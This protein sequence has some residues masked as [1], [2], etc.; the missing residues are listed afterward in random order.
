MTDDA[1]GKVLCI[2]LGVSSHA[3]RNIFQLIN[4][5]RS[6]QAHVDS[7]VYGKAPKNTPEQS[8]VQLCIL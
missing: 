1:E 8:L 6:Y 7:N 4:M 5:A 2:V 3:R